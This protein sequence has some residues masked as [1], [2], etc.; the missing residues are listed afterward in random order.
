MQGFYPTGS[1][2]ALP[3]GIR[4]GDC[5]FTSPLRLNGQWIPD[6]PG[7]YA[8]LMPDCTWAPLPFQPVFFGEIQAAGAPAVVTQEDYLSWVRAASGKDLYLAICR[9]PDVP[10]A[11]RH[12]TIRQLIR[13]YDPLCNRSRPESLSGEMMKRLENL[14][15]GSRDQE[16][17]LRVLLGSAGKVLETGPERP[18]RIF[19]FVPAK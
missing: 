7:M 6:T 19:G 3:A 15:H 4:F 11:H 2:A 14:E 9:M 5:V 8:V 18:K 16:A 12:E 1:A 13:A 17:M 10:A